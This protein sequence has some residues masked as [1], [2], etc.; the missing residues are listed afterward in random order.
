M[1]GTE[2]YRGGGNGGGR[3]NGGGGGRYEGGGGGR[4]DGGRY[5]GG[6][7]GG[8]RYDGRYNDRGGGGGGGGYDRRQPKPMPTEPPFTAYVGN[9]SIQS[10]QGDVEHLFESEGLKTKNVRMVHDRETGNFKRFCYVEFEDGADLEK[11][12][13]L[14]GAQYMECSIRVDIADQPKG[15]GDRDGGFGDRGRGRGR[16]GGDW[17]PGGGG[18][19]R[20]GGPGGI[21]GG[22]NDRGGGGFGGGGGYGGGRF[23]GGGG[24][25]DFGGGRR[26]RRDSDRSRNAEEFREPTAEDVANRP[27]LKLLPR[28]VK[29]PINQIAAAT[30]N[31]SIFGEGKPRDETKFS[32][33]P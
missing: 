12:L 31:A 11:A 19:Y 5:D 8:G 24:G 7:G 9:L 26:E 25:P 16:G 23:S 2:G 32:A 27:R 30:S 22:F 17:G 28:T 10:V 4:Y 6:G 29:D 21:R 13:E 3:Y 33:K 18:R 1:A 20:D 15:R 14:D